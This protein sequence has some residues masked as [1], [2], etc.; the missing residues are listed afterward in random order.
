MNRVGVSVEEFN[1]TTDSWVVIG[2]FDDAL[3]RAAVGVY[4][5]VG[6]A[7]KTIVAV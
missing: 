4:A 1:P 6:F 5:K 2:D 7:Q 3:E